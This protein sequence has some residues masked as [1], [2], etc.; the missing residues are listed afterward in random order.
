M[1]KRAFSLIIALILPITLLCGC[2]NK[3]S[4]D[5]ISTVDNSPASM[6]SYYDEIQNCYIEY[7]SKAAPGMMEPEGM[8]EYV[9]V[10]ETALDKFAK[11]NP[12]EKYAYRHAEMLTAAKKEREWNG[13]LLK[14]AD[15][16]IDGE[17]LNKEIE[18]V[19]GGKAVRSE[20]TT[21]CMEI[22]VSMN[23]EPD[24]T[25]SEYAEKIEKIYKLF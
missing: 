9:A 21:K 15:G 20:F 10:R 6:Q 12:P 23:K 4:L 11:L 22:I 1:A 14:Y 5:G 18:R 25:V 8:R 13:V 19:F 16:A 3:P 7:V 24:I 17:E 2:A